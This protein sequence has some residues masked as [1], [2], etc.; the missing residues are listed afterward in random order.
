MS[1]DQ[2][3]MDNLALVSFPLKSSGAMNR[4]VAMKLLSLNN[5]SLLIEPSKSMPF[6]AYSP[7]PIL[8]C[9][10]DP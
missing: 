2:M 5:V 9:N 1:K 7:L 6:Q 10:Q 8:N 4:I 3:S